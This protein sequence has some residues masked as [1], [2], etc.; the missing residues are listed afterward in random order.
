MLYMY[1]NLYTYTHL[2]MYT[3]FLTSPKIY[4]AINV[5]TR[6]KL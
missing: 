4:V 1:I 2:Y 6:L 3:S 5:L